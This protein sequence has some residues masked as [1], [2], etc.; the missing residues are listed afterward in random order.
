M[1]TKERWTRRDGNYWFPG[2]NG[3]L[4]YVPKSDAVHE[5]TYLF[6]DVMHQLMPD[7]IFDGASSVD[8]QRVY[9]AYRMMSEAVS[10][11]L[12]DMIF[13][14]GLTT[15]PE[16]SGYDF[17]KRRIFPLFQAIER[18]EDVRWLLSQVVGFVLRGEPGELPVH[19]DAWRAFEVKYSRFFVADFQWTRMNWQNL[20]AREGMVRGWISLLHPETF[21]AQGLWFISDVVERVGRGLELEPLV[22]KLFDEVWHRRIGPALEFSGTP[23]VSRSTS[24]GFRRWLTGQCAFFARYQPIIGLPPLAHDLAARVRDP[25]P[26]ELAERTQLRERFGDFVRAQA[27][28]G[29]ISD[30]DAA[31]FPDL[32]PLFDP[33]F[34][35]DYDEAQQEFATVREASLKAFG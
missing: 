8:H 10:L 24:K 31:L 15:R 34:L 12:A 29:L 11:V 33:Y 14:R 20:V 5:A 13:V 35:R 4:P 28:T 2:L 32:F 23:D 27:K 17:G 22:E 3:G 1:F 25:R 7:L 26:F 19:T 9:I 6:H 18:R 16:L 21:R 30:D